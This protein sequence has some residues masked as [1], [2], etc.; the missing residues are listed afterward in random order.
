MK[1]VLIA[2]ASSGIGKAGAEVL[3]ANGYRVILVARNQEKLEKMQKEL[4]PD[5]YGFAYDLNDIDHIQTILDRK[6]TRLN[7]SHE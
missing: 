7:S 3:T 2:G 6:S 4:G 1:T 5:A